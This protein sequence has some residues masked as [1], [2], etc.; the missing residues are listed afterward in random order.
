ML[1]VHPRAEERFEV[2]GGRLGVDVGDRHVVAGPGE[3]VAVPAGAPHRW[4]AEGTEELHVFVELDPPGAF[5]EQIETFFAL[6]RRG[7]LRADGDLSLLLSACVAL[8]H[9][10]DG[11]GAGAPYGLQRILLG[12]TAGLARLTGHHRQAAAARAEARERLAALRAARRRT[13]V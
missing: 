7:L 12:A 13:A 9:L 10:A 11:Y 5:D 3:H 1:H 4:I 2:L 6:G 8:P